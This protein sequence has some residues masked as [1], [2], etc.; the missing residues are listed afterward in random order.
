MACPTN[1][2]CFDWFPLFAPS[3]LRVKD[4]FQDGVAEVSRKDAKA[5]RVG[6]EIAALDVNPT[7][8]GSFDWSLLFAP[9]R[10][11]VKDSFQDG[12][13]E[14]SRKDAKALRFEKKIPGLVVNPTNLR[15]LDCFL[16]FAPSRLG[17]SDRISC[18]C[19]RSVRDS[20]VA[21][22]L[23][24]GMPRRPPA[25]SRGQGCSGIFPE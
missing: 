2:R 24:P 5:L 10:L 20:G 18:M 7:N 15:C 14:V 17:V 6:K 19:I 25:R 1:L 16:F 13:A 11:G 8:L 3:R 22:L 21:E 12:V 9:S 23:R 4:S